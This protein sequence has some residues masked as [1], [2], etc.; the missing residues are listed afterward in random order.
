MTRIHK[1]EKS[2]H[3]I[4]IAAHLERL[5]EN[6]KGDKDEKERIHKAPEHFCTQI[7]KG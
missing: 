4:L 5:F 3:T 7:A 1:K 2:N 6:E